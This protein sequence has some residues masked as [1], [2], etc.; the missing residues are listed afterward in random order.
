M[1]GIPKVESPFFDLEW[2]AHES[3][4]IKNI[5]HSLNEEGFAIIEFPEPNFN[6][7]SESIINSLQPHFN[8]KRWRENKDLDLRVHDAWKSNSKVKALAAN[9]KILSLLHKLYG[10][11]AIPFQTLNFPV[12][13]QQQ[14][15]SDSV[16]FSSVPERFM[17]GVWVAFENTDENNGPLE[18][19]PGSHKLPIF[20]NQ[21]IGC[22]HA[23]KETPYENYDKYVEL[24][25]TLAN[26]LN[27]KREVFHAQ[28]GQAIIWASNLL[29]GGMVHLDKKRTRHSQVTHYFF[30]DCAY[31]TPLTN[32]PFLDEMM[33]RNITNIATGKTISQ[34]ING[35]PVPKKLMEI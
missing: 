16:H 32:E 35:Q 20:N 9:E 33:Y 34:H 15:H 25:K 10:R 18:Y 17:C 31:Y 28:K 29:H 14:F 2:F 19:F 26:R 12:G 27:L 7:I 5:A 11:K 6:K 21:Q 1:K 23:N 30:E 8:L 13:T 24:W 3:E 22:T 4:E